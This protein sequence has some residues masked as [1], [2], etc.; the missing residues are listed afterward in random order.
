MPIQG[1]ARAQR[2]QITIHTLIIAAF[3]LFLFILAEPLFDRLEAVRGESGLHDFPLPAETKGI[4]CHIDEFRGDGRTIIEV[5]GWAFIE[6]H[7]SVSS[8]IYV[9]LKS[10]HRTYIFDTTVRQ[11]PDVTAHFEQ[12]DLNLDQSGF[13]ALI[14]PRKVAN[15]DYIIGIYI[16][17]GDIEALLY[18]S[19]TIDF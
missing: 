7:D 14:P 17:K 8:E 2:K 10:P 5:R 6:G 19:R 1:W 12:F 9:V 11:R 3:L 4:K 13:V 18:K 16:K 15:G